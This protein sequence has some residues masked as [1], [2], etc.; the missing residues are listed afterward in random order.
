MASKRLVDMI[1]QAGIL[2]GKINKEIKYKCVCVCIE[3][4]KKIIWRLAKNL[5]TNY[6]FLYIGIL[7]GIFCWVNIC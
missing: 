3:K 6:I 4:I 5:Y 2:Q 1:N 7:R